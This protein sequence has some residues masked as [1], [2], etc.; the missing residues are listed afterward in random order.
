VEATP[1]QLEAELS[2]DLLGLGERF[3]DEAFCAELYRA[4]S[5]TAWHKPDGPAGHVALS[6]SRAEEL[7]NGLRHEAG[8]PPLALAQTGGEG[9]VSDLVRDELGRLGWV[10][11]P[12]DTGRHD[13]AH[14]AQPAS[15]PP[16][17]AGERQSPAEDSGAWERRAHA[18][19]DDA[20]RR[21]GG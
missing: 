7:V 15:P 11:R 13:D 6:W 8:R 17:D 18:E 1:T 2:D 14:L 19:A 10:A 4:L 20:R 16:A 9:E 3:A 21:H 12:L 5:R